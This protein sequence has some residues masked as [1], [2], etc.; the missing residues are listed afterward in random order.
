MYM[1]MYIYIYIY[2][3][4]LFTQRAALYLFVSVQLSSA[5]FVSMQLSSSQQNSMQLVSVILISIQSNSSNKK[6]CQ[7]NQSRLSVSCLICGNL[8]KFL[9]TPNS[10]TSLHVSASQLS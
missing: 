5:K 10:F 9:L 3:F 2:I 4:V 6:F 8:F 1:Y 7:L